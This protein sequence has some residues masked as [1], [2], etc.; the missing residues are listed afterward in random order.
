V[1]MDTLE[2]KKDVYNWIKELHKR[3]R[4]KRSAL[5]ELVYHYTTAEGIIGILSSKM[6]RATHIRYLNDRSELIY[7]LELIQKSLN[8]C[9]DVLGT[10]FIKLVFDQL[11]NIDLYVVSFAKKRGAASF[12]E[13][14]DLL[15]QWRAYGKN[16]F[17]IGVETTKIN[18]TGDGLFF[19]EIEYEKKKQEEHIIAVIGQ[20]TALLKKYTEPGGKGIPAKHL[21]KISEILVKHFSP[22]CLL[23][24]KHPTFSEEQECRAAYFAHPIDNIKVR[25]TKDGIVVPYL[26][27]INIS[28]SLEQNQSQY[29]WMPLKEIIVRPNT[30]QILAKKSLE[31]LLKE[32]GFKDVKIKP[33]D[34]PYVKW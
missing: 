20:A 21:F 18:K 12:D 24:F 30:D 9:V 2:F 32:N 14:G 3:W 25:A 22:H 4:G 11:K 23:S 10:T 8:A 28:Q 34:I 26:D 6:I 15:S 29:N 7:P 1:N 27:L 33:S 19:I 16:G 13:A 31:V 17:A 5:P